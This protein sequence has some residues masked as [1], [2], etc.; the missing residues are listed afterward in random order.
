MRVALLLLLLG[1]LAAF[2]ISWRARAAQLRR[3]EV[4]VGVPAPLAQTGPQAESVSLPL[5]RNLRVLGLAPT[6]RDMALGGAAFVI[7]AILIGMFHGILAAAG[8]AATLLLGGLGLLNVMAARRVAEIAAAMPNFLDRIRQLLSIGTSLPVAFE[9]ASMDAPP[10]LA[11]LLSPAIRRIGNG[12]S[13][14]DSLQQS[15]QD[16][17]LH[18]MRLFVTAVTVNTRFGGSLTQSLA[19][20]VS[21]LRKR[22]SIE[23]ELRASTAQIRASAWVLGLLPLGVAAMI[24]LQNPR[25]ADWF[26]SNPSGRWMLAYCI[27]SQIVGAAMMRLIVRTAY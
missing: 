11:R 3:L 4:L 15:A 24:V 18:E 17:D 2:A 20:L 5:L 23:R 6:P 13:F 12:G 7:A 1:A 19:N 14:A 26:L 9:R 21:Y 25:Y 22:A 16:I 8:L 27:I 10:R